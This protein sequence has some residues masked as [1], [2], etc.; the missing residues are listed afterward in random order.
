MSVPVIYL[1]SS[2]LIKRYIAEPGTALVRE[3]YLRAYSGEI[4]LAYSVWNIG[5]VLGALDR[6]CRIGR[7]GDKEYLLAKKRFLGETRRL[8][9]LGV[10]L[11]TP[12]RTRILREAWRLIEKHHICVAD[13]L[14]I[15]TA[16]Y[17]GAD[18]LLTSDKI[19]YK[20]T[21]AEGINT[22]Y[23]ADKP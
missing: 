20:A 8:V 21:I 17:V 16:K 10:A 22:E 9:R 5:E 14:Q 6:A 4:L 11:V 23:I 15:A 1:D 2:A 19:L 18:K 12:V 13:A 7:L 3:T